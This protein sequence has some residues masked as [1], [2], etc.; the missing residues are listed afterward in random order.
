[1]GFQPE[2]PIQGVPY[3][4]YIAIGGIAILIVVLVVVLVSKPKV[5]AGVK[6]GARVPVFAVPLA[7]GDVKGA[8]DV[9]V[10]ANEGLRGKVPACKERGAGILNICELYE[11]GPVVLALFIDSG[12]CPNVLSELQAASRRFPEVSFAAVAL[13]AQRSEARE[14]VR[15]KMLSIPVGFDEEGAL[16]G[17]YGFFG[18][19]QLSFISPG[20]TMQSKALLEEPSPAVLDERVG[21]LVVASRARGWRP[22]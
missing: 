19:P 16:A 21:S 3:A 9:A 8:A 14:L 1:V 12:S 15:S 5:L 6:P 18:C 17:L 2:S 13:K 7:T 20:G 10:H 4:R 11:R 22:R